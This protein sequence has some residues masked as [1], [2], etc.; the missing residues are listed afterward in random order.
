MNQ[1]VSQIVKRETL[2]VGE[3]DLGNGPYAVEI[4]MST[5]E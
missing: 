1:Q 3:H 5:S 2:Y 4:I